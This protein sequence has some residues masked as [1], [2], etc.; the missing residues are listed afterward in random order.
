MPSIVEST[1]DPGS[2]RIDRREPETRPLP[3]LAVLPDSEPEPPVGS[4]LSRIPSHH[5]GSTDSSRG[6]AD[7]SGGFRVVIRG[8]TRD[9]SR[10]S[11]MY[12]AHG[13][14]ASPS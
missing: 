3:P 7:A 1:G 6:G 5:G 9:I 13:A 11:G 14:G 8:E 10:L 12:S 2:R 4:R